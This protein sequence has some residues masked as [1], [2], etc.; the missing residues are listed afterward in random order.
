MS[1]GSQWRGSASGIRSG[2]APWLR[3]QSS[4]H[5]HA[6]HTLGVSAFRDPL[7]T[8]KPRAHLRSRGSEGT[9]AERRQS[10]RPRK[11]S[12]SRRQQERGPPLGES[13][14]LRPRSHLRSAYFSN[15]LPR[16]SIRLSGP[17]NPRQPPAPRSLATSS[18]REKLSR[19]RIKIQIRSPS[20]ESRSGYL[21]DGRMFYSRRLG[22]FSVRC[23][24]DRGFV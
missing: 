18:S 17:S 22:T 11:V 10:P 4:I 5:L 13:Q 23:S 14:Y 2:E 12:S 16:L 1:A 3:H 21:M 20:T 7:H 19:G 8:R 9:T 6:E 24:I 15:A